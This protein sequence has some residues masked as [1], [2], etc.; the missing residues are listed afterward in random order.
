[1]SEL[2][3]IVKELQAA[4]GSNAKQDVL[5][6]HK[7]NA[8]FKAYMKAVYDPAINYFQKRIA[9]HVHEGA[10]KYDFTQDTL[11][12][13]MYHL[14]ERNIT[15]RQAERWLGHLYAAATPESQTLIKYIIDRSVGAGVGDTMVLKTWPDLYFIPGYMRCSLMTPKIQKHFESLDEIIVQMKADGSFCYLKN[16]NGKA[17]AFT[18]AGSHYP[19]WLAEKLL[20]GAPKG[21]YVFVGE[22]LV[23]K[24]GKLLDRSTGNGIYNSILKG[25]EEQEYDE[26]KFLMEAWDLLPVV[27]FEAGLCEIMY[28]HRLDKL[29]QYVFDTDNID[30]INTDVVKSLDEAYKIYSQYT[31]EGYEGAVIKD[32]ASVWK[33]HTSPYNVKLKIEF[34]VDLEVTAMLEGEGKAKGMLGAISVRSS[35]GLLRCDVGTGMSDIQRKKYW[36]EGIVGKIVTVK[37]N[38]IVK[39]RANNTLSLFLPVLVEV[40]YDKQSADSTESCRNQLNAVKGS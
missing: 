3:S 15:G 16:D 32:G 37:A 34:E 17:S 8:L 2:Y 31:A 4:Q 5:M 24:D 40:R 28:K 20:K 19:A 9:K 7:D 38:D 36:Q 14:A 1:M 25:G 23:Y 33:D 13:I 26:Y 35:D 30:V 6:K 11:D 27:D 29:E 22:L 21:A 18:R 39:N 12:G 10:Q